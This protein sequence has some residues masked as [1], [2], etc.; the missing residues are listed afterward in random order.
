MSRLKKTVVNEGKYNLIYDIN[1]AHA[2]KLRNEE[3]N[4][5]RQFTVLRSKQAHVDIRENMDADKNYFLNEFLKIMAH[6]EN[7]YK[8]RKYIALF[9]AGMVLAF[10]CIQIQH[11]ALANKVYSMVAQML[12]VSKKSELAIMMYNKLRAC[13][14]T[15]KD[16]VAKMFA[17][18]QL[19]YAYCQLEKY[20]SAIIAFKH[21][22]ALAWTIKS[23]EGELA[24]Y[25]GL[26]LMNLY[27]G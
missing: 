17:F 8:Q 15:D 19:G 9:N 23:V 27:C 14:H 2:K 4:Q 7:Y 5:M 26:A 16:A 12:L 25:E 21:V 13:A 24:A 1:K 18:K 3:K 22:L 6:V 20:E 10:I 11:Y